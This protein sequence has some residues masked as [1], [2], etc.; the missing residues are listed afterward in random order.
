MFLELVQAVTRSQ[1]HT[2]CKSRIW[3]ATFQ[4]QNCICDVS[5][6]TTTTTTT[7]GATCQA[8]WLELQRP[9]RPKVIWRWWLFT[10]LNWYEWYFFQ[11]I[12]L[13]MLRLQI[14]QFLGKD[15]AIQNND[16]M[17]TQLSYFRCQGAWQCFYCQGAWQARS[18][19]RGQATSQVMTGQCQGAERGGTEKYSFCQIQ[20]YNVKMQEKS[21]H[22]RLFL[23][24][25]S[26]KDLF[27]PF[28]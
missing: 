17:K 22:R 8:Q 24:P 18:Q 28:K 9:L 25:F 10:I 5:T 11:E 21:G 20:K 26:Q 23:Q 27:G 15:S 6:T 1:P 12:V 2:R 13:K 16:R 19:D 3:E 4:R 14:N 7:M